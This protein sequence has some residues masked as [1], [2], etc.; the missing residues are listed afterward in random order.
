MIEIESK[1]NFIARQNEQLKETLK[2][3]IADKNISLNERWYMF[4]LAYTTTKLGNRSWVTDFGI[5]RINDVWD[6]TVY[7]SR[8]EVRSVFEILECLWEDDEFHFTHEEDIIFKEYCIK[9]FDTTMVFD[10]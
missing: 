4:K 8:H 6:S 2:I 10:W 7:M 3:Y 9:E 1:I 5:P